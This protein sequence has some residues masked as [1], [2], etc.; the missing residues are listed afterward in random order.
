MEAIILASLLSCA[1]AQWIITG[2][3]STNLSQKEKS[4]LIFEIKT[5]MAD[6]CVIDDDAR[7]S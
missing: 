3:N 2:V 7:R 4:E 1:D 5:A 6:D